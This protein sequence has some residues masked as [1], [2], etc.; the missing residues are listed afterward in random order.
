LSATQ[1]LKV[2]V[3]YQTLPINTLLVVTEHVV[4]NVKHSQELEL[5]HGHGI[6]IWTLEQ[7][8]DEMSNPKRKPILGQAAGGD[9]LDFGTRSGRSFGL[10]ILG[11][12]RFRSP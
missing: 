11:T 2:T 9:L 3:E 12:F 4:Y 7:V 10:K 1:T 8:V 5:I 6:T